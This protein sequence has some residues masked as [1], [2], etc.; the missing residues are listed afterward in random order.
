VIDINILNLK[1][2]ILSFELNYFLR[3]IL[4]IFL[5]FKLSNE[6]FELLKYLLSVINSYKIQPADRIYQC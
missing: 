5:V 2:G 3:N 6:S 1:T 4:D